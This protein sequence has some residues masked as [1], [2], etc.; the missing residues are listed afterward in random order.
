MMKNA[1]IDPSPEF[2]FTGCF[3][4]SVLTRLF[5]KVLSLQLPT[6]LLYVPSLELKG[7]ILQKKLAMLDVIKEE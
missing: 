2:T 6:E 1:L 4:E 3:S 5:F 7:Q